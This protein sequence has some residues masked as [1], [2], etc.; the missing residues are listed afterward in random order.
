MSNEASP[1]LR[2]GGVTTEF[3]GLLAVAGAGF[4]DLEDLAR[5]RMRDSKAA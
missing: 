3:V 4:S 2:F 1:M 5:K